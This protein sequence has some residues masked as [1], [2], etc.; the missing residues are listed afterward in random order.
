MMYLSI[1]RSLAAVKMRKGG[2]QYGFTG[3]QVAS[4][5]NFQDQNRRCSVSEEDN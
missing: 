2:F 5:V 3:S 1:D 4:C